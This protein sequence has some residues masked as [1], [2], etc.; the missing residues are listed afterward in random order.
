MNGQTMNYNNYFSAIK[1][2]P[3]PVP[4]SELPNVRMD[5]RGIL[6]Y[7]KERNINPNDLT[8]EEREK[9]VTYK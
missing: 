7:A 8:M 5:F 4:F 2:M 1:S 9:F 3:Q 6:Q